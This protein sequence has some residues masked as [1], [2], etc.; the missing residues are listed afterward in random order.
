MDLL[1]CALASLYCGR[2]KWIMRESKKQRSLTKGV[3]ED[4]TADHPLQTNN[5]SQRFS[6]YKSFHSSKVFIGINSNHESR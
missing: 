1:G 6:A 3:P 2:P 5:Q 4:L